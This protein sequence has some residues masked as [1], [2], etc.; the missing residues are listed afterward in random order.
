MFT[1]NMI[2]I[3]MYLLLYRFYRHMWKCPLCDTFY[4]NAE[5]EFLLIDKLNRK[6]MGYVLQDL[7]CRKCKEIKR[8]NMSVQC[9][10]SGLYGNL[11]PLDLLTTFVNICKSIASK[12]KMNILAEIVENTKLFTDQ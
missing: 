3:K 7:Q 8:E 1:I 6:S 12:C 9:S 2:N 11:I 5:I 10:C 4:D